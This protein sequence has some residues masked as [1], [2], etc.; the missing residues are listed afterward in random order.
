MHRLCLTA[1]LISLTAILSATTA[2]RQERV[3]DLVIAGGRVIDPESGLDAT[4]DVGI[5]SD[6][7]AVV[8]AAPLRGRDTIDARGLVVSPGFID[9]HRHGHGDTSYRFA[10]RDGVTSV[11]ELEVGTADVDAWYR[12]LGPARLINF[13][14][15]AGHI[16]ARMQVLGDKGFLLPTGPGREAATPAQVTEILRVVDA[17]L[18]AGGVAT[19][20]GIAYTPGVSSEEIEGVLRVAAK[21]G[22]FVHV[23]LGGG[24]LPNLRRFLD[25]AAT[26]RTSLQIAH[27]NSTAGADVRNW[28]DALGAARAQKADVTADLYP[29]TASASL[30]QSALYDGWETRPDEWFARMQWAATG[31]RLTRET[32]ARY[33]AQ[34][35]SVISHSGTEEALRIGIA[36]PLP[37]FASDGGRDLDDNPTHPRA[38]GTF[39]RILGYYVREQNV[40]TLPD[41]LRRMTIEPARRL[42]QRVPEMRDRG[43]IRAGA[44]ADITVFDPATVIDRSTYTTAAAFSEGIAYVVVNGW[45]VVRGGKLDD[46]GV[47][48]GTRVV[49]GARAPGRPIRAPRAAAR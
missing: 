38:S 5:S 33:R 35:G 25:L 13:G 31:E 22:S 46:T 14:V 3:F 45:P 39:A 2:P 26:T 18:Q 43:R 44:F 40:L 1:A 30:I 20:M 41:A 17:G 21:H 15:G 28:L 34:G 16:G 47:L 11:F 12:M 27:V 19:G 48:Q 23:H 29:Y 10:A 7:I 4:R 6:R 8:S 49:I 9:L 32:F 42:E 24:G 37:M 36:D